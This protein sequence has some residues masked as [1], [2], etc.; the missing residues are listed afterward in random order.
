MKYNIYIGFDSRNYGQKMAAKVCEESIYKTT[1]IKKED[2]NINFLV[3]K[4]LNR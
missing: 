2:L 4:D 3:L 1:K